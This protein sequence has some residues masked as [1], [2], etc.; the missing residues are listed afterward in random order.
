MSAG[1][2]RAERDNGLPGLFRNEGSGWA[3]RRMRFLMAAPSPAFAAAITSA[4]G[5]SFSTRP[6]PPMRGDRAGCS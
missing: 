2:R 4:I 3:K 5:S 1:S 6:Q